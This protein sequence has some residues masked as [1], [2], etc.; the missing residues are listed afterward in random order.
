MNQQNNSGAPSFWGRLFMVGLP[1]PRMDAVAREMV[2]DLQVGGIILFARNIETPEQVWELCKNLQQEALAATGRPLLISVD[3]EG[4]PV[5][6]LQA[7]FTIIP[8][9]RKLGLEATAREVEALARQTARELQMVGINVNLAPVLDVA[10]G[11]DCPLGD[12]AYGQDPELVAQLGTAAIRGYLAG[13]VLPVAKHF[14]GLGDTRVDSHVDLPL[15]QSG[16][17]TRKIDMIPF[18]QAVAAG[19]PMIMTAHLLVPEWDSRA[20]TLSPVILQEKLRRDLGFEGV[21]I[22]DDLEMGAIATRQTAPEGAREALEAGADLL[23][24]CNNWQ[25]AWDAAHL[26]T[27]DAALAPRG[28]DAALRLR[29]LREG[30]SL[31]AHGLQEVKEYFRKPPEGRG[32]GD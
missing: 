20:A 11:L 28:Q 15:S 24:I 17:P 22:T 16:D 21:I 26:L 27:R 31:P 3:Q 32:R 9:A 7:P 18:R 14:P 10:R 1:G 25:A 29:R 5:Q 30:I 2:R 13:G 4:G 12:R 8:P 19:A 6:R 23:L